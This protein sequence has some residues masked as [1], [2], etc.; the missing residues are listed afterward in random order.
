MEVTEK[1]REAEIQGTSKAVAED[2]RRKDPLLSQEGRGTEW[3]WTLGR[4]WVSW[5][6][7]E[8]SGLMTHLLCEGKKE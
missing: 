3:T 2:G 1:A 6:E 5:Q 8:C 7:F 4:L